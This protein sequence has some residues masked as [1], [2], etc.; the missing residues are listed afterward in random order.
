MA[1]DG[2]RKPVNGNRLSG[3][4]DASPTI[5][6]IRERYPRP[7]SKASLNPNLSPAELAAC[8]EILYR[9]LMSI[10]VSA[11]DGD[12][13]RVEAISDALHNLPHLLSVGHERGWTLA[14]FREM[15]LDPLLERYPDLAA[16]AQ[17]L[18]G[19]P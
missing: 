15:F 11:L 10:R 12:A 19:L 7:V 14:G 13:A 16:L 2:A 3:R 4:I 1:G 8:L 6:A 17:P 9:G 18:D 5:H